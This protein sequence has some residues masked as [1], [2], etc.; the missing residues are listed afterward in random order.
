M[1]NSAKSKERSEMNSHD[2]IRKMGIG[3]SFI[4]E[5]FADVLLEALEKGDGWLTTS[6][7]C[8]SVNPPELFDRPGWHF[9]QDSLRLMEN[10]GEIVSAG[11]RPRKWRLAG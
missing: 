6:D 5:V 4:E 2:R 9:C 3:I 11:I 10:R 7:I 1:G 8:R